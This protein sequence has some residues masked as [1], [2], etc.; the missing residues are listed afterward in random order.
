MPYALTVWASSS[1][2]PYRGMPK[3]HVHSNVVEGQC[4][5]GGPGTN[6]LIRD[7]GGEPAPPIWHAGTIRTRSAAAK[8]SDL[9]IVSPMSESAPRVH[10]TA[11]VEDGADVGSGTSV[12]HHAHV[13]GGHVSAATAFSARTSTSTRRRSSG[14]GA[15]CRTTSACTTVSPS[16]T[17]CSSARRRRSPM[18]SCP[19][20]STPTGRSS[21]PT[22]TTA[23]RS[24]PTPRSCA[25]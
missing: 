4:N 15:R 18:I 24:G 19:G 10:P 17:M 25:A 5:G 20:H 21:R 2:A 14:I 12:W 11:I 9:A 7:G 3:A 16:A 6:S 22:C 13:R 1:G 23:R 8:V